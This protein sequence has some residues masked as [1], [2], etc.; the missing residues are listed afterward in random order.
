MEK[1]DCINCVN[2]EYDV[3]GMF[4]WSGRDFEKYKIVDQY[5]HRYHTEVENHRPCYEC[6]KHIDR[7]I[8][9]S[10]FDEYSEEKTNQISDDIINDMKR[11]NDGYGAE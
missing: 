2:L 10:V 8:F 6:L 11:G 9:D 7:K 4:K 5:C 3:E 1:L